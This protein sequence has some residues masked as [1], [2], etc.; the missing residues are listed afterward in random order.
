MATITIKNIPDEIYEKI[1]QSARLH[2][3]SINNEIIH[4]L[5]QILEPKPLD[6]ETLLQRAR[7]VRE[8]AGIY[9]TE[10]ELKKLKNQGRR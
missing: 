9:L 3:R 1:K 5:E 8:K 7:A 4:Y 10:K 2:R 6:K